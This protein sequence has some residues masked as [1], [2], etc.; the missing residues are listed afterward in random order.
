M[1]GCHLDLHMQ[2]VI[3]CM[4]LTRFFL[5]QAQLITFSNYFTSMEYLAWLALLPLASCK[6]AHNRFCKSNPKSVMI[7]RNCWPEMPAVLYFSSK[8]CIWRNKSKYLGHVKIAKMC[9]NIKTC[10][11]SINSCIVSCL[12]TFTCSSA[13]G[14]AHTGKKKVKITLLLVMKMV[15]LCHMC[16]PSFA[17]GQK[18][19]L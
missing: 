9:F 19:S 8:S 14:N 17:F 2:V 5:S 18:G 12:L 6:L 1:K 13:V 3:C 7:Q 4:N 11:L 15:Q 10:P 16:H